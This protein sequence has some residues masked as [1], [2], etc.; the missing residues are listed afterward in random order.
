MVCYGAFDATPAELVHRLE[1]AGEVVPQWV[2]TM[3]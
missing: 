3:V 2:Y 1:A